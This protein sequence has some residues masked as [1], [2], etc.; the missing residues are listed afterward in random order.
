MPSVSNV[1]IKSRLNDLKQPALSA[2]QFQALPLVVH[3][4]YRLDFGGLETVLVECVNRIAANRYRHAIVCLTDYTD[5]SEKITQP[6]VPIFCLHKP[7]GLALGVHVSLWRLLRRLQPTIIHTYNLAAIE[8]TLAATLSGVPIRVHAEHGRDL[9]DPEGKNRKHNLLRRFLIPLID[10]FVPVSRDLKQW[11]TL[12]IGVPD[13]K[14][15]LINNGVDTTLFRAER[16]I[17]RNDF[18]VRKVVKPFVIGTVGRIQDVKNHHGLILAFVHLL[19]ILPAQRN[20]LRLHI[21]GDG[22]LMPQLKAQ[23][24]ALGIAKYVWLPGARADIADIM[25]EFS[26]FVLPSFAEGT[27]VTLLE[28]MASSLP[29]VASNVG[30]IPDVIG[31]DVGVLVNPTEHKAIAIVLARYCTHPELVS[32]HGAAGRRMVE[33]HYSI[34]SMI[35]DYTR[36][37]DLLCA[38]KTN[39]PSLLR[40]KNA[41]C[42]E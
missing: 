33:Q 35:A 42:V 2:T 34:T 5:F 41:S 13:S 23:V 40:K 7:A 37:Y 25:R 1:S 36:L 3:L 38:N 14:N 28:A 20:R 12:V 16:L 31:K 39:K 4:V 17:P 22:P 19:T 26:V 9:S 30:G 24:E 21:V 6:D 29:V 18:S 27:P 32:S 15:L 11:L 10:C 8:Y